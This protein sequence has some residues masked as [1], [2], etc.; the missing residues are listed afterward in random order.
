MVVR[1]GEG[2]TRLVAI[3][4]GGRADVEAP[5]AMNVANSFVRTALHGG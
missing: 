1:D 4:S 5:G 2:A 3:M